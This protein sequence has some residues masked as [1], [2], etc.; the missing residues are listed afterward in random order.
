MSYSKFFLTLPF[1]FLAFLDTARGTQLKPASIQTRVYKS[2]EEML[3]PNGNKQFVLLR[4]GLANDPVTTFITGHPQNRL[5][6]VQGSMVDKKLWSMLDCLVYS[7]IGRKIGE[8]MCEH[9]LQRSKE[10]TDWLVHELTF[11][12]STNILWETLIKPLYQLVRRTM[13]SRLN[14]V[15]PT[16]ANIVGLFKLLLLQKN[17]YSESAL[18][19]TPLSHFNQFE[20]RR[21]F[22]RILGHLHD[23]NSIRVLICSC[24]NAYFALTPWRIVDMQTISPVRRVEIMVSIR[25]HQHTPFDFMRTLWRDQKHSLNAHNIRSLFVGLVEAEFPSVLF[26]LGMEMNSALSPKTVCQLIMQAYRRDP[27][28]AKQI[29]AL[30]GM[31]TYRFKFIYRTICRVYRNRPQVVHKLRLIEKYATIY[32]H[33][34]SINEW[35]LDGIP[36]RVFRLLHMDLLNQV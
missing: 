14:I 28:L 23:A 4:W 22:E 3:M 9:D 8:I 19:W 29:I 32:Y 12:E 24:K 2:I 27:R 1:L 31:N 36:L 18:T 13:R 11:L 6:A 15:V 5:F 34:Q 21:I 20:L 30:L 7:D 17:H 10:M 26:L 35:C 16:K 33:G 25:P